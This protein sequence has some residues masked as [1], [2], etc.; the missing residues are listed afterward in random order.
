[1]YV[2]TKVRKHYV[3][4]YNISL[5]KDQNY[6]YICLYIYLYILIHVKFFT[7]VEVISLNLLYIIYYRH[8]IRTQICNNDRQMQ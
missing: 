8:A 4:F 7:C 6:V 2:Y 3:C 5:K 1:M